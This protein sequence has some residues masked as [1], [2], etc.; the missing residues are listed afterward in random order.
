MPGGEGA[1]DAGSDEG[2]L[3]AD[4]DDGHT[5]IAVDFDH[6]LTSG[7]SGPSGEDLPDEEM[8]AW[9]NHQYDEDNTILIWTARSWDKAHET[10]ARLTEWGVNWHGLRMEK[11]KADIYVDDKGSTPKAE[12]LEAGFD[13]DEDVDPGEGPT[14]AG[15]K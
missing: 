11:G 14:E 6:T 3:T 10:V 13:A 1:T 4:V 8:V 7:E 12:L 9:V 15:E 2:Q 5:R